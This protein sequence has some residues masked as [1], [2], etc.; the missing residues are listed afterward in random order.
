MTVFVV[1][2]AAML[3][4]ALLWITLPLLRGRDEPGAALA[5]AATEAEKNAAAGSIDAAASGAGQAG[6]PG[7]SR[8]D[9]LGPG[10]GRL[11]SAVVAVCVT[12]LAVAMY[13][14]LS[15]W[16]WQAVETAQRNE[17]QM[18]A[19][20]SQLEEK[21][22]QHPQD[23]T[24]WMLLGRS[25]AALARYPNA[26]KAYQHAYDLTAGEDVDAVV[27]LA[28]ALVM[29]DE[30]SLGGRAGELFE[31]ALAKAPNNPKA[32]WYAAVGALRSG[33]L[34]LARER[35]QLLLAQEPPPELRTVLERQIQDL[36]QQLG[37]SERAGGQA[38]ASVGAG[39]QSAAPGQAPAAAGQQRVIRVSVTLAPE[40][41][42]RLSGPLT[43]FVL[44]RD[45]AAPGPPLAAQRRSSS[46]I[47]LTLELTESDA[48]MPTHSI[49]NA[50]RVEVVARLSQSG[51]PQARSGDFFGSADYDFSKD[52]G[53][54]SIVIDR[55]V[56]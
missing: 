43:L 33:N 7:R 40:I 53:P 21:L 49:A 10:R 3:A 22:Q 12:G 50:A 37:Q 38:P 46:E 24:G 39:A 47:P 9:R 4:A 54:L 52:T 32:L 51:T 36:D 23:V 29:V 17:V 45:P 18:E 26:V 19:M 2:C 1:V 42:Q 30:A 28:E 56:P 11:W 15:N 6:D 41:R 31:R 14:G 48:M 20:L 55:T 35:L 34:P 27:G 8:L 25:N 44:A 16:N 13:L 5:D